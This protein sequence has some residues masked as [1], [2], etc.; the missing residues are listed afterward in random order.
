[1]I[2]F[3]TLKHHKQAVYDLI[4]QRNFE[5]IP[6]YKIGTSQMDF[7]IG[8]LSIVTIEQEVLA[9]LQERKL[10]DIDT[11]SNWLAANDA[12]QTICLSDTSRWVLRMGDTEA[13]YIHIHPARYSP[14]TIR[15][16]AGQLKTVIAMLHKGYEDFDQIDLNELNNLRRQIE[17]SPVKSIDSCNSIRDLFSIMHMHHNP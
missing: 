3:N 7:Y 11:F 15:V 5:E 9:T 17:L 13:S 4:S 1:M 8:K 12:Y 10:I 6:F 2:L 16:K 14:H